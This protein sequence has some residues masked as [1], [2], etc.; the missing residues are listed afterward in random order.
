MKKYFVKKLLIA[1]VTLF[2][3][4]LILFLFMELMPGSPFNDPKLTD[5]QRMLLEKSYG[6]DQPVMVRFFA[7][8]ELLEL[9]RRGIVS[10]TAE[11]YNGMNE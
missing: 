3:V 1:V 8:E 6:L 2:L 11:Q 10:E 7:D 9:L 4:I 5:E